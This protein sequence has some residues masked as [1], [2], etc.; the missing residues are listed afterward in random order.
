MSCQVSR[1]RILLSRIYDLKRKRAYREMEEE[2]RIALDRYPSK[3]KLQVLLAEA[4]WRLG[5]CREAQGLL[6]QLEDRLG[7]CPNSMR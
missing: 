4:R 2:V 6:N 7:P 1:I 5:R 3:P